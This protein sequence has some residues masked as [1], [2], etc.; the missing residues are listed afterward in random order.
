MNAPRETARRPRVAL[1]AP[2]LDIM[3]GQGVE[4]ALLRDGLRADG[5]PVID[6]P[7]NPRLPRGLR[8]VRRLRG[9]RTVANQLLY[10]P[11]LVR[12]AAADVAHVF[13]ASYWSFLLAP[14]PAMLAARVFGARVVLHYHSGEADDH[15]ARWGWGVHPWLRL[16]DE[17]VVP[18]TYLQR[19]FAKH[20]HR[21][22]VILNIV[23]LDAFAFRERAPL[24]PRLLSVRNLEAYYQV[25]TVLRAFALV[26]QRWPN[27]TLT[28]AG[29][30]SRRGALRRLADELGPA[31]I[32]FLGRVERHAMP[33]LYAEA[34]I[35]LNASVVDNQ[36]V[37]LLEAWASGV[38]VVTTA[39]GAIGDMVEDG[40]TGRLVPPNDP[41]AM[42]RATADLLEAPARTAAMARR[43]YE[44]AARY[45]W[46]S[47][48][49]A[50]ARVYGTPLAAT[51]RDA[52]WA[53]TAAGREER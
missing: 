25:E 22:T 43:G 11:S 50:W 35:T 8:W 24:R 16:A 32:R 34:D 38:A 31:G 37:S 51:P 46:D 39:T 27:A 29:D 18:S 3:G 26:R 40:R 53:G 13:S 17:I 6:V 2:S 5:Y 14:V 23:D 45:R 36:P 52:A 4:A 12:L 28:V 10:V 42:A 9:V 49:D 21:A 1:V 15:L 30:G 7:I 41:Q 20:G 19:V 47:V 44:Q 48:R 33:A